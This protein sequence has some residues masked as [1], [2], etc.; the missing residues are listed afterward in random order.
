[1]FEPRRGDE[2]VAAVAEQP[3][4]AQTGRSH[5]VVVTGAAGFVGTHVCRALVDAGWSVR[6]LVR[7]PGKAALR[8]A[9]LAVEIRTGDLRDRD[10]VRASLDGTDVVIHLA[11]IAVEKHGDTYEDSNVRLTRTVVDAAT[12]ARIGRFI[13]VSQ[14]G[15]DSAS[16]YRFLRSKGAAQ[17]IVT[18]TELRWTV[19]RPSV[20]FGPEDEFAN[21]LARLV[22]LTPLV[23]P[24][25]GGGRSRFQPV[26]VDDVAHAVVRSLELDTTLMQILAL[27]G[28][29]ILTLE[30]MARRILTAMHTRRAIVD[31]PMAI[32]RPIVSV[33]Q[34]VLPTPPVTTDLLDL[35]AIDNTVAQNALTSVF[36]ISPTPFAPEELLY[37]R[38]I[39]VRDA[40]RWIFSG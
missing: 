19:L 31:L 30:Q 22:R 3:L 18:S 7:D 32:A 28:P 14:N 16:P 11:A 5:R 15:A 26:Y 8:L 9:H 1:M 33:L 13:F 36:H 35:L 27:G 23:L 6:A 24:L 38:R 34:R 37:L 40:L 10:F 39:S 20:I 21:V 25:P 29:A 17:N 2:G 12:V 4:P